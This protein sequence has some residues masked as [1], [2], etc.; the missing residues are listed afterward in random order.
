MMKTDQTKKVLIK[1][2]PEV[3][4]ENVKN[5]RKSL[6]TIQ[7]TAIDKENLAGRPMVGK[8]LKPLVTE[9]KKS[10]PMLVN[11][12]TQTE[13]YITNIDDITGE[14]ASTDYWKRL[15]EKRQEFLDTSLHEIEKLKENIEHLQEENK[16][17]KEMLEE[18]RH[19]VKVF[20]EML[21]EDDNG[22]LS[23]EKIEKNS[24]ENNAS[25]ND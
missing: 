24:E 14:E 20:Q 19:L 13:R 21:D 17:C 16:I 3:Q 25:D 22:E 11:Q 9:A 18:S 15:A 5:T 10:K 6:R 4:Q 12:E 2:D 23:P 7:P 1:I 8:D